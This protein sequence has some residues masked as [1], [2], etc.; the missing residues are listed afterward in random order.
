MAEYKPTIRTYDIDD[1]HY[2]LTRYTNLFIIGPTGSGKTH[3]EKEYLNKYENYYEAVLLVSAY[4]LNHHPNANEQLRDLEELMRFK[5]S[6]FVVEDY[7]QLDSSSVSERITRVVKE[8]RK[9]GIHTIIISREK[10]SNQVIRSQG[11]VYNM[12]MLDKAESISLLNELLDARGEP[13]ELGGL[14]YNKFE[15]YNNT[16]RY[17]HQI[18]R[19]IE[20]T[21]KIFDSTNAF[22]LGD[23]YRNP[24][25]IDYSENG[26][27]L[28]PEQ[29]KLITDIRVINNTLYE[30]VKSKPEEMY[31]LSS[32][33]F[34]MFVAEFFKKQGY[35]VELTPETRDGGKDIIVV[36]NN[37]LGKL[38]FFVEC[39]KYSPDIP[40]SVNVIQRLHG[41]VTAEKA[42][43]GVVVTSSYFS[44][45]AI[46][47][48]KAIEHQMSL[49]NYLQLSERIKQ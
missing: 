22:D 31:N 11:V 17:I 21:G 15:E 28:L 4:E 44:K 20:D 34:E 10:I 6:L 8:G 25:L 2:Q 49:I 41:T 3:L 43:A 24:F 46:K 26:I 33:E 7:E 32:R 18:A 35:E 36:S 42:T 13:R 12:Q 47:F 48:T 23:G 30:R 9:Y 45:P 37:T 14:F 27:I 39:K 16:P 38:L 29:K 19:W 1:L 5:R 40:V